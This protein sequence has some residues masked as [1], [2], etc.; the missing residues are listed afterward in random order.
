MDFSIFIVENR[1]P[2]RTGRVSVA[3]MAGQRELNIAT[4]GSAS[5]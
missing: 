4:I 3:G 1:M 5:R 2:G